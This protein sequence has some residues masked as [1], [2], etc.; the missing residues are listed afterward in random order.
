MM[1]KTHSPTLTILTPSFNQSRYIEQTIRS[2]LSQNYQPVE[3]IV[4]DGGSTDGTVDVLKQFSHLVWVSEKD[5]GQADA[6]NKGF[7]RATGEIVGW[8]NSDDY[9]E[10][11]IFDS[12]MEYFS[13]PDAMWVIGNL[14]YVYE[15]TKEMVPDRSRHITFDRLAKNPDIV[16]Q[17]P[18]FFRKTFLERAGK[19]NPDYFMAMD[20]D[21]WIRLAKL[22][23]PRMVDDNWAYFRIHTLQKT[24]H[25]NVLRQKNEIIAI[26]NREHAPWTA[27][28]GIRLW[29][30]WFWIKGLVKSLL[31]TCGV[32]SEK[33]RSK[34]M[35]N[36][37]A[38]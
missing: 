16:R 8:I 7:A 35:R 12:V 11:D 36:E 32:I 19:W 2:V 31:I 26:L 38:G 25:A 23:A 9:Y 3:H 29:K 10:A 33:Y 28:A 5:R 20:Y 34:P 30:R 24:S 4:I 22:S 18:T 15:H 14:T 21:L 6:L 27:I 1:R 13:D 37:I 17:A